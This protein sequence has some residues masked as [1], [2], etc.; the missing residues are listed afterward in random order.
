MSTRKRKSPTTADVVVDTA[1]D[2]EKKVEQVGKKVKQ[3][4]TV[5]WG[6]LPAWQQDNRKLAEDL[7]IPHQ[8]PYMMS[9]RQSLLQ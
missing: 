3:A 2:V 5:A 4:L 7:K 8:L 9:M 1:K 6:D